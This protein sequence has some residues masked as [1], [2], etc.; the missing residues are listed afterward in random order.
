[1]GLVDTLGKGGGP[2]IHGYGAQIL[3]ACG[4]NDADEIADLS[5]DQLLSIVE[6]FCETTEGVRVVRGGQ[7]PDLRKVADWISWARQSRPLK[8]A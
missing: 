8:A 2:P 7:K 1:M 4:K 5:P 3:V 6:P